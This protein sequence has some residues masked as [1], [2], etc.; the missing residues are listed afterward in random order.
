MS[1]SNK[2][3]EQI[4][5][6][7]ASL[8]TDYTDLL[9][10]HASLNGQI[11]QR[12]S[13]WQHQTKLALLQKNP[14]S[15]YEEKLKN[16]QQTGILNQ[17]SIDDYRHFC[18]L[19]GVLF[20]KEFWQQ[21]LTQS[22]K[23][24][25]DKQNLPLKLLT[26]KWQQQLD[27]VKS[28]WY[29]EQLNQLQQEFIDKL[30]QELDTIRQLAEQLEQFGFET[31][32]WLDNSIS[33]L[34]QQNIEEMKRWLNYL[35]QDKNAQQIAELLGKMRQ[36]EQSEKIEQVKQTVYIQ[37]P[38]IDISSREEIIGLRLGKD[39]EY[40]LPSELA[41]M[42]DEETSILFDLKFLESKL[43]CFEL[44][45]MTYCDT[46]TEIIVEQKNQE[47][48][49][50]GAMILCVDTSGSMNGLP[51]NIA[52][53]MAL[54]LGIKAKSENRSCFIINFSTRIETFE[55]TSKTGISN[56]I[57]FLRQSFHGGTDAAP[58][59]RH[60]LKMMEQES[61]QKADLLMISDFMMNGLPDDLL[62]SIEI[63]RETG[64]Q[65]N[66]LVIGDA[67][68]SKLLKTHFDREWIYNPNVQTIQELVQFNKDVF[69]KQVV[70]S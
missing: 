61:Y 8:Q 67:F 24:K 16:H 39:L 6:I 19:A 53:A 2:L 69:N 33:N 9:K 45:G 54:F 31:G 11:Q 22:K 12:L 66:S 47:D 27:Y 23:S 60:A 26:E 37:N 43:M 21:E 3:S 49:K 15:L 40:V 65:F 25:P 50:L 52:K 62:A 36:I 38:Q 7:K 34:S 51:E 46:P 32:L 48:E 56:L 64:N 41:L 58:A 14:F 18:K 5:W 28:Q 17:Q 1:L 57:A 29:L 4:R 59:L 63:Q 44:Q 42:A 70:N 13:D 68:M 35:T 20:E 30:K 10:R 55:L